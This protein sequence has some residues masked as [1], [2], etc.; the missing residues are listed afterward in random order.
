MNTRT[1][2]PAVISLAVF[3]AAALLFVPLVGLAEND[4]N[5]HSATA[6]PAATTQPA[7]GK[8]HEMAAEHLATMAKL[9]ALLAEAKQAADSKDIETA[10]KKIAE[11]QV[12]L[13]K[14]HQAMHKHMKAM[15]ADCGDKPAGQCPMCQAT[16]QASDKIV[17]TRCP[18]MG[19]TLKLEKVTEKLTREFKGRKI[20]FCCG[21]CPAAW[22]SLSDEQKETKLKKAAAK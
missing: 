12:L 19:S 3:V 5:D 11:A 4:H 8:K 2:K 9:Q 10:A 15:G 17:N 14:Q 1:R 20:G 18:M 16:P 7:E 13:E 6:Q 21:G 22:D